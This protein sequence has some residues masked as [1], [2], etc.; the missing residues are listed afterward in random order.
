MTNGA[1]V[2]SMVPFPGLSYRLTNFQA[3]NVGTPATLVATALYS[4]NLPAGFFPAEG[5]CARIEMFGN[6]AANANLKTVT[7]TFAGVTVASDNGNVNGGGIRCVLDVM[8]VGGGAF[9]VASVL[10]MLR[11]R[12]TNYSVAIAA[13]AV[14]PIPITFVGQNGVAVA[15]D[16]VWRATKLSIG[17]PTAYKNPFP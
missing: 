1:A 6:L 9:D 13:S 8:R 2:P 5:C 17:R 12:I 11:N 16:I 4:F 10:E 7:V 15:N 3:G 14:L